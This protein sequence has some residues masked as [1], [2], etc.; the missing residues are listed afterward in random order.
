MP[1]FVVLVSSEEVE[2]PSLVTWPLRIAEREREREEHQHPGT[3]I[4]LSEPEQ[5]SALSVLL[6][7]QRR[8]EKDGDGRRNLI[9]KKLDALLK[10]QAPSSNTPL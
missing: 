2:A 10:R 9:Q 4:V 6:W 1:S 7:A 5:S 3:P 8:A